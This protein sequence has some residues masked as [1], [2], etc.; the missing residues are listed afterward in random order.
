MHYVEH[1][2]GR[3]ALNLHGAAVD[4]R[5][6]E[7][8]FE[9]AFAGTQG[10]RR[11][12][13]DLPGMGRTVAGD[14]VRS[15]D[16]VVA[17]LLAFAEQVTQG[18]T[19]LLV[20]HSA[21]AHFALAMAERSMERVAGLALICPLLPD[22]RDVPEP[23]RVAGPGDLGDQP[24]RDYFVLQTPEMLERYQRFVVPGMEIADESAMER[25]AAR[26]A[27]STE[28]SR[29]FGGPALIVA[30]RLDATVGYAA[31]MDL[32]DRWPRA[33]AAVI[34]DAGHALP[35]ER[36]GLLRALVED[37]VERIDVE[38]ID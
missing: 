17:V 31:A 13:P 33:T 18:E 4:H 14:D 10:I 6:S 32:A 34:D 8:C 29:P 9:A 38:R 21:G 28:P 1:G 3:P 27:F 24:F 37:W 7:A 2:A 35:H 19:Y 26:W 11:V 12:Y 16:D 5:E 25:I 15:A 22:L 36:P 20:A 30:G 23:R